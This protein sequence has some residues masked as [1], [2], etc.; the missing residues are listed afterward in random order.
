[1]DWEKV[2]SNLSFT[3]ENNMGNLQKAGHIS[4]LTWGMKYSI[5]SNFKNLIMNWVK[6]VSHREKWN[7]EPIGN[8]AHTTGFLT[9][10]KALLILL[11]LYLQMLIMQISPQTDNNKY[12]KSVANKK[13]TL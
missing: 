5:S 13:S 3:A 1:M 2:W 12:R 11:H 9:L 8:F 10:G 6:Y 7:F 4:A